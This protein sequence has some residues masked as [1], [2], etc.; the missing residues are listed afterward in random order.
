MLSPTLAR[1]LREAGLTW[2]PASGDR[3]YL[4]DRGMD[5]EVFVISEM[6]VDV[7]RFPHETVIGFNGV[8][9][10]A[11]DSVAQKEAVWVPSESQLRD[12]LAEAF[13]SLQRAPDGTYTVTVKPSHEDAETEGR[14]LY[15]GADPADA[16]AL[17]LL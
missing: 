6:T 13:V 2:H 17:A 5:D 11:L 7:H 8:T 1:R 10:W 3:F 14:R 16:Y 4:P 15:R 9:E 12:L